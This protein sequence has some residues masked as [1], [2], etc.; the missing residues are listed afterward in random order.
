MM[1]KMIAVKKEQKGQRAGFFNDD[2]SLAMVRAGL[3]FQKGADQQDRMAQI[4]RN[5]PMPKGDITE[6]P[7]QEVKNT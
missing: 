5:N 6:S 4:D 1:D 2:G 3:M 7:D